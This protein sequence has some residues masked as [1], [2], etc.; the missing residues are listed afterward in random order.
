[1]VAFN[2]QRAI[3]V[4]AALSQAGQ[5]AEQQARQAVAAAVERLGQG[6]TDLREVVLSPQLVVRGTVAEPA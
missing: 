3:G 4:L 5:N 6:R 1:M 2:D